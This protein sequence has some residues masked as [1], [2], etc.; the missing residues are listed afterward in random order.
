MA[1]NSKEVIREISDSGSSNIEYGQSP[2]VNSCHQQLHFGIGQQ[3]SV[4]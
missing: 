1:L 2:T 3:P 4:T